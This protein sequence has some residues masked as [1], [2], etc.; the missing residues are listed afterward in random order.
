MKTLITTALASLIVAGASYG[1]PL[2]KHRA[3]VK[4]QD[5]QRDA[6]KQTVAI[7]PAQVTAPKTQIGLSVNKM[8]PRQKRTAWWRARRPGHIR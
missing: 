4:V 6:I 5:H 2:F 8:E 1:S 7:A 3:P